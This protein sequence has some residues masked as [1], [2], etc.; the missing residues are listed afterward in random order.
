MKAFSYLRFSTPEQS[1]GD[2]FRRQFA[3]AQQWCL[4]NGYELDTSLTFHDL[5]ISAFRGSNAETG[6]LADFLEAVKVGLVPE[7]S[8]L[9]VEALDRLSRMVP[10]KA[11]TVLTNIVDAGIRVVTLSDGR[12]YTSESLDKDPTALLIAVVLFMRANEE[13]ETKARRLRAAWENK[14]AKASSKPLTSL[15]PA[16]LQLNKV[17]NRFEIIPDRAALV[18][19]IF[20][21]SSSGIGMESIAETFNKEQ[22]KPWGRASHWHKSYISKIL[23]NQAVLGTY[24]PHTNSTVN[25][26]VV[27]TPLDPIHG[28]F[29][30]V[31][32]EQLFKEVHAMKATKRTPKHR[33]NTGI[34]SLL[35][36]LA[37]C[38][39]C[40]S[41]MTRVMKGAGSKGGLPKLVCSKAKV[42]AGCEYH[43]VRQ[44]S[45]EEAIHR[46]LDFLL[47]LIP[48]NTADLDAEWETVQSN[49]EVLESHM[50]SLTEAI[51]IRP[52]ESLVNKLADCEE[53]LEQL[54]AQSLNLAEK[55]AADS[56]LVIEA[57]AAKLYESLT[58][59]PLDITKANAL[60]RQC[61]KRVVINFKDGTLDFEWKHSEVPR[62]ITYAM[63]SED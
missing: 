55:I 59:D 20:T 47:T 61:F 62:R 13:S 24:T 36:S 3:M 48:S 10:R 46:D 16:W 9:L 33:S 26:R 15:V 31:I 42:G 38:P 50:D 41:T 35:A 58:A 52:L 56:N 32:T 8:V 27:R 7:G 14:R 5:G 51:S 29:P 4:Q 21:M 40:G 17:D 23:S 6:K 28:Y 44:D 1:K 25:G 22:I 49:I 19:R 39:L 53:E 60:L 57:R 45:V 34:K 18:Q 12:M 54:K 43:S 37:E 63:P 2:S 11:V 30:A